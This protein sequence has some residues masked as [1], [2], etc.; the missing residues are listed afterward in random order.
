MDL[1]TLP[2]EFHPGLV[3]KIGSGHL[4]DGPSAFRPLFSGEAQY[5]KTVVRQNP[6][7]CSC[8]YFQS[9]RRKKPICPGSGWWDNFLPWRESLCHVSYDAP[10]AHPLPDD[11]YMACESERILR[12]SHQS[13]HRCRSCLGRIL[14][15]PFVPDGGYALS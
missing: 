15:S 5:Q 14:V 2:I 1:S 13:P 6:I 4:A 12:S 11:G 7:C 8:S 9:T 3:I 10:C